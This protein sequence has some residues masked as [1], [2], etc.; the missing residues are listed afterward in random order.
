MNKY[1]KK[2]MVYLNP[3]GELG[4]SLAVG[5]FMALGLVLLHR[6]LLLI[7]EIFIK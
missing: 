6:N 4:Y 3:L 7:N 2:S 1:I 5:R